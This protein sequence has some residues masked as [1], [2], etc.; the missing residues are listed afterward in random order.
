MLDSDGKVLEEGRHMVQMKE[1]VSKSRI[2]SALYVL[3][4]HCMPCTT[5]DARDTDRK[6]QFSLSCILCSVEDIRVITSWGDTSVIVI[7]VNCHKNI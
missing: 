2:H 1:L 4:T 3:N 7:S 5:I 6:I